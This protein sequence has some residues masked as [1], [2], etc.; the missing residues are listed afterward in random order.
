MTQISIKKVT[1]NHI[2]FLRQLRNNDQIIELVGDGKEITTEQQEDWWERYCRGKCKT[3][4]G[5]IYYGRLPVG[6]V[7]YKIDKENKSIEIGVTIHPFY[8]GK[9]I[10]TEIYQDILS[11]VELKKPEYIVKL[12]VYNDNIRAVDLYKRLGFVID[13]T[14]V[15]CNK[16]ILI[17]VY[18]N[19]N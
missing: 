19:Q 13:S 15:Y 11:K 2:E 8:W 1:E 9:G 16:E 3:Q 7:N 14:D 17:M 4:I 12:W 5:I 18:K 6:Y 10:A